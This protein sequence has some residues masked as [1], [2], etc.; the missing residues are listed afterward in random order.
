MFVAIICLTIGIVLGAIG[1]H[2][3]TTAKIVAIEKELENAESRTSAEV[4]AFANRI[5]ALI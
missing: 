5:R 2:F 3:A 4:R 1:T